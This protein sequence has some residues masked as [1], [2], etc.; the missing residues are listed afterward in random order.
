MLWRR[1]AIRGCLA[2]QG[3]R[4][5]VTLGCHAHSAELVPVCAARL[6][7]ARRAAAKAAAELEAEALAARGERGSQAGTSPADSAAD[8][9]WTYGSSF[10]PSNPSVRRARPSLRNPVGICDGRRQVLVAHAVSPVEASLAG[11]SHAALC[12]A[13]RERAPQDP[14]LQRLA[15]QTLRSAPPVPSDTCRRWT[16]RS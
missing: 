8:S 9:C 2:A 3:V 1:C 11:L 12:A 7:E 13:Q 14:R 4:T 16:V 5:R 10:S 15:R 6:R